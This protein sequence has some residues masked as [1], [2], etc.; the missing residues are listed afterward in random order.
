MAM[1]LLSGPVASFLTDRYGCRKVTICGAIMASTGFIIS[2][3]A[4]SMT[5]L[6]ITFGILAGFGLSLCYVASVVIVAYYFD[7]KRSFATG[8]AVCG[9]GIGTFIFAPLIQLLLD[10][11]GWRGDHS[12]SGRAFF[13]YGGLRCSNEGFALDV[14]EAE[15]FG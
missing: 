10:E 12:N 5:V 13:E 1:P 8:L 15:E 3:T 11:Y 14:G 6:C 2:S 9:S 7:K 4:N